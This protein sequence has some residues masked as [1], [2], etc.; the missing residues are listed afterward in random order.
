MKKTQENSDLLMDLNGLK[1]DNQ[2]L[3][4]KHKKLKLEKDEYKARIKKFK[5][6]YQ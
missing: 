3:D 5:K 6:Q 4:L 1:Q 2:V